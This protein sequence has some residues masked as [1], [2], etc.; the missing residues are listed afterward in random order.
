MNIEILSLTAIPNLTGFKFTG[1]G[2]NGEVYPD[3]EVLK[4]EFGQFYVIGYNNL[5]GWI[6][7]TENKLI[8]P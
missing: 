7:N 4:N 3:M 6:K 5:I 8:K 1:I 2:Y